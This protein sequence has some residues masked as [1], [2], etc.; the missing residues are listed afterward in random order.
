METKLVVVRLQLLVKD[1]EDHPVKQLQNN[2]AQSNP[3]EVTTV[4]CRTSLV[5]DQKNYCTYQKADGDLA[6]DKDSSEEG[7]NVG[8]QDVWSILQ[9]VCC[10]VKF[11]IILTRLNLLFYNPLN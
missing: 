11:W 1:D 5:L 7:C 3:S 9:V 6:V 8:E 10:K 4:I 2:G